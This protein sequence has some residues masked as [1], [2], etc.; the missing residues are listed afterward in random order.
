LGPWPTLEEVLIRAN[1]NLH[2]AVTSNGIWCHIHTYSLT[3]GKSVRD[4]KQ[5]FMSS[6]DST[7]WQ[8]R[9]GAE[10]PFVIAEPVKR[11]EHG[12][13]SKDLRKLELENYKL[14]ILLEETIEEQRALLKLT[15]QNRQ[16]LLIVLLVLG[17]G[18]SFAPYGLVLTVALGLYPALFD[19]LNKGFPQGVEPPD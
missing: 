6:R 3:N 2:L 4:L 12:I 1:K 13:Q 8:K 17:L 15:K 16:L 7:R 10:F 9:V 5:E 18:G 11:S 19:S 14:K